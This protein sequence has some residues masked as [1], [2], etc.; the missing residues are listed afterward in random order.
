MDDKFKNVK[1]VLIFL[2]GLFMAFEK[3]NAD[4]KLDWTDVPT[5][6][7]PAKDAFAAINDVKLCLDEIKNLTPEDRAE[8][9]TWFEGEFD[10]ASDK[11]EKIIENGLDTALVLGKFLLNL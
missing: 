11:V 1:E 9:V 7:G 10:I 3:A 4:G 2:G 8:L 6:I 5:F